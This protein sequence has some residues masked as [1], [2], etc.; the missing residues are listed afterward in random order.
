ME[1]TQIC[2]LARGSHA[3][4][5][6]YLPEPSWRERA[7][8]SFAHFDLKAAMDVG[9]AVREKKGIMKVTHERKVFSLPF[10]TLLCRSFSHLP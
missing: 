2:V 4:G 9:K 5:G 1:E 7:V 3:N 8:A 6:K 10:L